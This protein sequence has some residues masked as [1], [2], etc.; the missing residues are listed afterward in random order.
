MT[1]RHPIRMVSPIDALLLKGDADPT[2]RPI[3]TS[4][5]VLDRPPEFNRLAAAFERASRLVPLMRATVTRPILSFGTA[6]WVPDEKFDVRDHLRQVGVPGDR[7]LTA[8]LAMASASATAPFDPARPLW[9]ATLVT[10]LVDGSAVVLLRAHHAI[11]DGVRALQMLA[12]LLDLEPDPPREELAVLEQRGA[13]LVRASGRL[14]QTTSQS[15]LGRHRLARRAVRTVARSIVRPVR[16]ASDTLAYSRSAMRTYGSDGVAPSPLL[17]NRGRGRWF[18]TLEL[19]L[20]AI[21]AG[22]SAE[23]ATVNDVFLAGLLGGMRR[24][25]E[26]R[27]A[28][29]VDIPLSFPVDVSGTSDPESGNHFS[30]AVIPGP[31]S[32]GDPT[33]RL[34]RVH[35]LVG[36]RRG[37]R[38]I[39]API[40]LA[41]MLHQVPAWLATAGLSAYSRRVDL[42]ASNVIGPDFPVYLAG[43]RV[44]TFHAF[45][46]LPG[47]PVMAVLVSYDGTCTVGFTIDPAAV[48]DPELLVRLTQA[49]FDELVKT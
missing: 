44:R 46:P 30:A 3:M 32:I 13:S 19:P 37:E 45:G 26:V 18:G 2:T 9:D 11:A 42:Q 43:E 14:V 47:L 27:G 28:D 21:K 1:S 20:D 49:S 16:T 31:S 17:E 10:E 39:D 40:R 29:V 24:F 33:A 15:M 5:L 8:V 6:H 38:G 7:T 34:R 48:D 22:A 41:P 25:H 36:A 12:N 35:E 4:A 23:G